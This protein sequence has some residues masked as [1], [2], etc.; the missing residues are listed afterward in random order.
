MNEYQLTETQKFN[1]LKNETIKNH[2]DN[3]INKKTNINR[4]I[5]YDVIGNHNDTEVTLIFKYWLG[6]GIPEDILKGKIYNDLYDD[7]KAI[8]NFVD[9][10]FIEIMM[11]SLLRKRDKVR[12]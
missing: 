12:E 8:N 1:K 9:A 6:S 2:I 3:Y 11:Y 7:E 4:I 5:S 10:L